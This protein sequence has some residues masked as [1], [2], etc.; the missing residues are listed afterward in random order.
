M[1]YV[2]P[3]DMHNELVEAAYRHRGYTDDEAKQASRFCEMAAWYGIKTHNALKA[4]HLDHLFGSGNTDNPG[5]VP[6]ATIIKKP[7]RFEA[8]QRWNGNKKLGQAVAFE[9]MDECM[10]MADK[11]GVG[12]VSVDNCT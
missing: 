1:E 6:N 12:Q 2:L 11:Y 3:V 7:S 8:A 4:L 9:A 5:C 10:A